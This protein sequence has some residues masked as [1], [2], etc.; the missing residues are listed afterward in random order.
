MHLP[1]HVVSC[2]AI[3]WIG[4]CAP[5]VA[6]RTWT[7]DPG[8]NGDFKTVTAAIAAADSGDRILVG[9][10]TYS[11]QPIITKSLVLLGYQ[12]SIEGFVVRGIARD[13]RVLLSGF[14]VVTGNRILLENNTGH[15]AL[16]GC[17]AISFLWDAF[18]VPAVDVRNSI[19]VT[20]HGCTF[21]GTGIVVGNSEL[22][23]AQSRISGVDGAWSLLGSI[24]SEPG[25]RATSS[26]VVLAS[27]DV[28]GGSA[29]GF[30]VEQP[31]PALDCRA[32]VVIVAA[33]S[34]LIAGRT[35][36]S[37][38]VFFAPAVQCDAATK[39]YADPTV[40][41]VASDISIPVV[42]GTTPILLAIPSTAGVVTRDAN[43][44]FVIDTVVYAR[45]GWVS[46][47]LI[48]LPGPRQLIDPIGD[49]WLDP[50][51]PIV[52]VD[53][54]PTDNDGRRAVRMRLPSSLP[55]GSLVGLQSL[56]FDQ[57]NLWLSTPLVVV[58]R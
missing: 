51:N 2:A 47:L 3:V 20:M 50:T 13:G 10:G 23:I 22:A 45:T 27:V 29:A 52:L 5:V 41:A 1:R 39:L 48:G 19:H 18:R 38:L 8:G 56:L 35:S 12:A 11:E 46:A 16:S 49:L 32:S 25:L 24:Q 21:S 6:Q 31:S 17:T 54:G 30:K 55:D 53:V 42:L 34:S 43:R 15:V 44:E 33:P 37:P 14:H 9:P 28:T 40:R 7:V 4:M 26:H 36:S 57:A 58:L